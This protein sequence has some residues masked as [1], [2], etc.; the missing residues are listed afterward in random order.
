LVSKQIIPYAKSILGVDISQGMVDLY[1]E[2]GQKEGFQG[3]RAVRADLKGE[4][5]ELD[6]QKFD[7]IICNMAYHHFEDI[8]KTTRILAGF[9]K[10]GGKLIVSDF[11]DDGEEIR[12]DH[13]HVVVHR[14]MGEDVMRSVFTGAGLTDVVIEDA[15]DYTLFGVLHIFF[16]VGSKA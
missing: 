14:G 5:G 12:K 6:G 10:A 16:T 11:R 9:L 3:M 8:E 4:E 2:T 1:N 7:V 13:A 15:F